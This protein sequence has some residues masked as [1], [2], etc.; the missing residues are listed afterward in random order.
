MFIAIIFTQDGATPAGSYVRIVMNGYKHAMPLA[1][2]PIPLKTPTHT[3]S[4][5]ASPSMLC[6]PPQTV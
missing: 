2:I 3:P 1:S 6:T 4:V 5:A